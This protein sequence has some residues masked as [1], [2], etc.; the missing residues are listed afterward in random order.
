MKLKM[1]KMN[2]HIFYIKQ[3]NRILNFKLEYFQK[4]NGLLRDN[5]KIFKNN[6]SFTIQA[7]LFPRILHY[8][9]CVYVT[10]SKTAKCSNIKIQN[11]YLILL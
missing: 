11:I 10:L 4:L 6:V 8:Y 3:K 5:D 1:F 2:L 7:L 9:L